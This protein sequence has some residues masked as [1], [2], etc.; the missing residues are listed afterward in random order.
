MRLLLATKN[1][2]KILETRAIL[3][4]L[5]PSLDLP[6]LLDYPD[7]TAPEENGSSFK[8]I[9]ENKAL[10]AA[11]ALQI[12]ALADDS[13]LCIPALNLQ[14]GIRSARYAGPDAT[15]KD[16]RKKLIAKLTELKESERDGYFITCM[17]LASPEKIIKTS[18]GI[19]EGQLLIHERGSQGFGYDSIFLKHDYS[20][21]FAEL[22]QEIKNKISHRAKA[23]DRMI[24]TLIILSESKFALSH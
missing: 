18:E 13:G 4:P 11:Q 9:A 19:C 14:P 21:T 24:N 22:S 1:L 3:K 12:H 23:I 17:T 15:D 20:N 10:H 6:S 8:E 5:F 2:G 16:N 7:Y